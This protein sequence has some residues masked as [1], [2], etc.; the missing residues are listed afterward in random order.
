MA[1]TTVRAK[2]LRRAIIIWQGHHHA[3]LEKYG[4]PSYLKL[5]FEGIYQISVN[6][7][8]GAPKPETNSNRRKRIKNHYENT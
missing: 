2:I 4:K 3:Y 5:F 8:I 1:S 6:G 7:R